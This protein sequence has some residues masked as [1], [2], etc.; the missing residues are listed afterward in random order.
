MYIYPLGVVTFARYIS[1]LR[2]K[3]ELTESKESYYGEFAR[4]PASMVYMKGC[5]VSEFTRYPGKRGDA[6][7]VGFSIGATE[8][9]ITRR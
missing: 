4:F 2:H 3:G 8:F 7:P 1:T 5:H 6:P 9:A